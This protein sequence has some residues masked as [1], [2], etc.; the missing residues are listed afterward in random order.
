MYNIPMT[1]KSKNIQYI[2]G[3]CNIGPEEIAYRRAVGWAALVA[4]LIFFFAL[5]L[6]GVNHWWRLLV[7][8]PAAISAAGFLQAH[9]Q[10][11]FGFA[12]KGVFNLGKVGS[13]EK[14]TDHESLSKDRNRGFQIMLSAIS[15]GIIIA[16]IAVLI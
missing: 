5:L 8:L 4:T 9:F 16:V 2:P 6:A 10:F 13:A 1:T 14:I 12:Q 11:C 15:I 3:V 7:A